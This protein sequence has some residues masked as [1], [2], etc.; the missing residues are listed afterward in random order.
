MKVRPAS[1]EI[2]F[3]NHYEEI[4]ITIIVIVTPGSAESNRAAVHASFCGDVLERAVPSIVVKHCAVMTSS[5]E[6]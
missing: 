5:I 1:I 4:Q 2:R 3:P 6:I